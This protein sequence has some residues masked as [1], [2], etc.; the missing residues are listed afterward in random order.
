MLKDE[1]LDII[2]DVC[3]EDDVREDLSLDLF[4]E[5]LLDS[6]GVAQLLMEL[7]DKLGIVI[8]LAVRRTL[9]VRKS[10]GC[11]CGCPGCTG[12]CPSGTK[13]K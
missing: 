1:I 12:Q 7:E 4:E 10:G 5:G 6:L 13:R 9:R 2:A 8:A 11:G 3:E